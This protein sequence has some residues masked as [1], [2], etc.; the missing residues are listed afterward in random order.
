MSVARFL[1]GLLSGTARLGVHSRSSCVGSGS[2]AFRAEMTSGTI[3]KGASVSSRGSCGSPRM[4]APTPRLRRGPP[5]GVPRPDMS[6]WT[7]VET[8]HTQQQ[9][10]TSWQTSR[11]TFHFFFAKLQRAVHIATAPW[12]A[13][14][15][16]PQRGP[17]L[18][19]HLSATAGLQTLSLG[20]AFPRVA[21][22]V[23]LSH[24]GRRASSD[25]RVQPVPSDTVPVRL[26][27]S[28]CPCL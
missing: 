17:R 16:A 11:A 15:P 13:P 24:A 7:G 25:R 4:R 20:T 1:Q 5:D 28:P 10:M 19:D 27:P 6:G 22:G 14:T 23:C 2:K 12:S 26:A 3:M 9:R 18:L 21:L 8:F